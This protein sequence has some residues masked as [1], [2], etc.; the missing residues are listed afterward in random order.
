MID[1]ASSLPPT[2]PALLADRADRHPDRTALTYLSDEGDPTTITYGQLHQRALEVASA[3]RQ[4]GPSGQRGLLLFPPGIEFV[5]GFFGCG[6]AGW[7]PV[8]T[9]YPKPGRALPRLDAAATDCLPQAILADQA[10]IRGID[11]SKLCAAAAQLPAVATDAGAASSAER[12]FPARGGQSHPS[13]LAATDLALL[14]YTSGSTSEPK[15]VMVTH[16]NLIANLEACRRAFGVDWQ[17]DSATTPD[18]GVFWLPA[19]HDMGLIGGIL[20]PLYVGGESVLISPRA[21]LQRPI[22]WLQTLSDFRAIISGAPNFAYQ[23]CVDRI[24]PAQ[25]ESL[26][27]SCWK[28]AFCGAEPVSA[29]TLAA[30]TRRFESI[31]FSEHAFLPCYG[32]AESTLLAAGGPG[33]QRPEVLLV[34]REALGQRRIQ[35][36]QRQPGTHP[37]ELVGCGQPAHG[38]QLIIVDPDSHHRLPGGEVGE[39]WLSGDSVASGYWNREQENTERFAAQ[40]ADAS[41][42]SEDRFFRTGDLGFLHKGI[43]F[44]TGRLKD[45]VILRGRN[46]FPQDIETTVREAVGNDA[47]QVA[48]FAVEGPRGESL[49][50][51]AEP[52]RQS[53]AAQLSELVRSIRRAVIDQHEVDPRHVLLVRPATVPLT[54]SGK[55]RRSECRRRFLEN[56]ITARYRWDR[57]GGGEADPLPMPAMPPHPGDD[58]LPQIRDLV[59]HWLLQWLVSRAGVLPQDANAEKPFA[60]YGLDSLTAV[61]LSGE[62]EDWSGLEL[63]PVIAW[64]HPTAASLADHLARQIVSAAQTQDQP[65]RADDAVAGNPHA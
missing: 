12:P 17:S 55:L 13:E 16:S 58:D 54:S 36:V 14:Q 57:S 35:P 31:G 4:I 8:P 60:D 7:I 41:G 18:R 42:G 5:V 25:T 52:P 2:L 26:D 3:L 62:L 65:R 24:A 44:V 38:T 39:I 40:L 49:V 23:L 1:V 56:E 48:A 51:V 6:Y 59:S 15:G 28:V 11:R 47:G 21:F 32:L 29:R 37:R 9:S 34:D 30:F 46:H 20:V 61:E 43:L 22:R 64:N 10:T 27:L 63:D 50:I 45:V 33:P 19:F 53:D